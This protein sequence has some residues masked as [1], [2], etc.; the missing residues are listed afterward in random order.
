MAEIVGPLFML[1]LMVNVVSFPGVLVWFTVSLVLYLVSLH[2]EKKAPGSV[3]P[4]VL[5]RRKA[6]LIAAGVVLLLA[7]VL[8]A[9]MAITL[10]GALTYM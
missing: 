10:N 1:F 2:K 5:I 4:T 3:D 7:L 8:A 9:V 6:H